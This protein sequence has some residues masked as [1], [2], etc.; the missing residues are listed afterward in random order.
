MPYTWHGISLIA[1]GTAVTSDT[2][3]NTGGCDSIVYL[4][5]TV[6]LTPTPV[7]VN[8]TT[9]RNSLPFIWNSISVAAPAT[10]NIATAIYTTT[11]A[12]GC[13]SVVT[14][15]LFIKDTS[16]VTVQ[17]TYCRNE[18]PAIWNGINIPVAA[19]SNAAYAVYSTTNIA[20]C[21]STV[22]LNL[23][24][25]DTFALSVYDTLCRNDLPLTWNG[26]TVNVPAGSTNTTAVYHGSS[27]H[28]CDSMVTLHLYIR[29]PS[30]S[31]VNQVICSNQLPY[32]WNG[33][34][35]TA[36]GPA[37]AVF[38]TLN[39]VG[40]DS[41]VTLNLTV[42]NTSA[43]TDIKNI[44]SSQLPYLW[45]GIS[46]PAGGIA[47]ATFTTPN[48]AGCDSIITLNLNVNN[49]ST[50]VEN[51]TICSVQLPY[52]WHGISVPAGGP[53]AATFTTLNAAGCDSIITLDLTVVPSVAPAVTITVAPG[54]T[55]P[56]GTPVTFT[57]AITNG[58]T[59]PALQWKKNGGNV[60][61]NSATYTDFS[62]DSAD[63]IT[64]SLESNAPCATPDTAVSNAIT[65]IVI[66][67][68]PPCL[69]PVTLIST[70][71][72]FSA[73]VF[74]WVSVPGAAGYEFVLDMLPGNPSSGMFTTDT[75]YHASALLPGT[76]YFHI[77]TRC[78]N[79]DYS[80]WIM[81][82]IIVQDENGSTGTIE[83]NGNEKNS[84]CILIPTTASSTYWERYPRTKQL[85]TSL[86][87]QAE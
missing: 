50:S 80:P 48:V 75:V 17:Q 71:I 73:A 12:N 4:N 72:Q 25:Y 59:L 2:L 62:I 69:V 70:D 43:A 79:G 77:R 24:V 68:P 53:A 31:M 23:T 1:G 11:A 56:L 42:N 58:G 52:T 5:L 35:V 34:S 66:T 38:T 28:G 74:R 26:L 45:N 40:C 8:D 84:A 81:I 76:Y 47:V 13:D 57:A 21:D 9:C 30:A 16:M 33:I 64:C 19:T 15:H 86:T 83:L 67:P 65:M 36:G 49:S 20:G 3:T 55:V 63:V 7:T 14:L 78:A 46:V 37:A 44:C 51:E 61:T 32:T 41:V 82:T 18:L 27:V 10:G 6:K 60:G 29:E 87:G 54:S 85:S 39:S 22:T